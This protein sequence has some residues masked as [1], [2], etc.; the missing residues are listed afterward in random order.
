MIARRDDRGRSGRDTEDVDDAR[1]GTILSL[2]HGML[3]AEQ[4][5]NL[6]HEARVERLVD[7][8]RFPGSRKHPQFGFDAIAAHLLALGI[9]YHWS[10][11]LGGR[12]RLSRGSPNSGLR[13][14]QFRAYA[15]HMTSHEFLDGVAD[16]IAQ[17]ELSR[18]GMMCAES[19]WWRCHRRL[20]A[21]HLVLV[22]HVPVVHL[23]HDGRLV[24]HP[25]TPEARLVNGA[26]V[27]V[28]A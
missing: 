19:L 11:S 2:G 21:D 6:L 13:N 15:D 27:Y 22:E 5:G 14:P 10:P 4:F 20:L 24:P 8:R 1:A 28:G 26:V 17:A 23:F 7:V 16:L 3:S 18:V 12:R 25:I 9:G